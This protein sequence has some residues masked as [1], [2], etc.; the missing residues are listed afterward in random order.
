MKIKFVNFWRNFNIEKNF[1]RDIAVEVFGTNRK[2][3]FYSVFSNPP[4]TID[5]SVFE[6]YRD[7]ICIC[8]SAENLCRFGYNGPMDILDNGHYLISMDRVDHPRH[9]RWFNIMGADLGRGVQPFF[10]YDLN[11]VND[12]FDPPEK[13]R[14]CAWVASNCRARYR[15]QFVQKLSKYKLVDC[16][17]KCLNNM[18][19]PLLKSRRFRGNVEFLSNYKFNIAFENSS[20]LGYC[21]EKIWWG[22]LGKA[23]SIYWGDK[24]VY[25]DFTPGSFLNRHDFD[26]DEEFIDTIIKIDNNDKLYNEMLQMPKIHNTEMLRFNRLKEFLQTIYTNECK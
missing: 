13:V 4:K 24:S 7:Y 12:A 21:T 11:T 1:L 3:L 2:V 14:F 5:Q 17:G 18:E 22:F 15:V 16:P 23:V 20:A 25:Q 10:G 8:Y 26:T 19:S 6:K 9:L